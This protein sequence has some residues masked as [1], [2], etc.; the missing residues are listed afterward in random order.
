M[1]ASRDRTI[2][3][4]AEAAA[5]RGAAASSKTH[6]LPRF[7]GRSSRRHRTV[8]LWRLQLAAEIARWRSGLSPV[9][10]FAQFVGFPRSGHS[11]VGALLDAHD[12]AVVAH[13]L[14]AVGLLRKGFSA[15]RLGPL[16]ERNAMAFTRSGRWW[17]G[18][19]YAVE[20]AVHGPV[21]KPV[22]IGDKKGDWAAR[23]C[24][25]DPGLVESCRAAL[26]PMRHAWILVVRHPFD[27]VATMSM[28]RGGVYDR[29][30]IDAP[31]RSAFREALVRAQADGLVARAV[32]DAVVDDY[33]ALAASVAAIKA[34]VPAEDWIEIVYE[35]FTA[36]PRESL[37]ALLGFLGL[38]PRPDWLDRAAA[39]VS[40]TSRHSRDQVAWTPEQ[41]EA[42]TATIAR[43]DFLAAYRAPP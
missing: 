27:N 5:P 6:S 2:D 41:R 30:A 20:G 33:R 28:R 24:A 37:A 22:V 9:E 17:N 10:T 15:S 29:L 11:L 32:D 34:R 25:A 12:E 36:A 3:P 35:D 8:P 21:P 40:P 7:E 13:E 19:R 39:I 38:E 18:F 4:P 26:A 23:W 14:D 31:S 43:H 16:I 1:V 42:L